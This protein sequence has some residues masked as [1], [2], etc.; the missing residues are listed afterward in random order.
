MSDGS[1][2]ADRLVRPWVPLG[3]SSLRV[4]RLGIGTVPLGDM[5]GPVSDEDAERTVRAAHALGASLFDTAPQY[6]LGLA[7]RRLGRV[8]PSLDRD[9]FVVVSKVGRL[10]RPVSSVAKLRAT[11]SDAWHR[12]PAGAS[13]LGRNTVRG[14]KRLLR[15]PTTARLGY[16]LEHGDDA[17]DA[18][19]DFSYD[20]ALRSVEESLAR[21]KL[22]RLDAVLIHD[23]DEHIDEALA[24]SYRAL[25]EMREQGVIGA[26]GIGTNR[27]APL[28]R[29]AAEADFDCFLLAGRYTLL[30]HSS[31][32]ELFAACT[33]HAVSLVIGGV[34]N[35]GMLVDPRPGQLFDYQ[36]QRPGS[37]WLERAQR[38][39]AVCARHGVPLPAA[40]LQFP[41]GNPLVA[42]VLTGVRSAQE[43]EQNVKLFNW[44]IPAEL[45]DELRREELVATHVPLPA[46]AAA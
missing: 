13:R 9:G 14:A 41:I 25:R 26:V 2:A 43:I 32:D 11:V 31:L 7:E 3:G 1:A 46:G 17:L 19:F 29:L 15:R 36:Q 27:V 22:D 6:G 20:G 44:P 21:L 23:P 12:G 34:F 5:I 16:P 37:P 33:E 35:S 8:L 10:L 28:I 4:P 38:I 45:W 18:V 24:G 39:K 40:A 30:D 42:T